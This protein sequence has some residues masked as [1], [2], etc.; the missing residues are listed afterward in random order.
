MK[1]GLGSILRLV[2]P[3]IEVGCIVTLL[4]VNGLGYRALGLPIE[5]LLYAGIA[6]GF[7][8]VLVGIIISRRPAPPGDRWDTPR[9]A[10]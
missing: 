10:P 5:Y 7:V 6:V 8:L 3:L 9:E 1:P 2:G 4:Q